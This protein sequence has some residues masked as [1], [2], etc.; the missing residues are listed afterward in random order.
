[1]SGRSDRSEETSGERRRLSPRATP[2]L[3][4]GTIAAASLGLAGCGQPFEGNY[5]F[6]NVPECLDEGFDA[7]VCEGEFQTALTQHATSAPRFQS[8]EACESEFGEGR[9]ASMAEPTVSGRSESVFMPFLTGYLVSSALRNV[10][11]FTAYDSFRR[12]NPAYT[13]GPVYRDAAGRNVTTVRD[14][15]TGRTVARPVN[16]PTKTVARGGFGQRAARRGFGG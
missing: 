9:C 7:A 14:R 3:A 6:T 8:Q 10:G 13:S 12:A 1:M 4:L 16:P 11:S 15:S 5:A 2:R